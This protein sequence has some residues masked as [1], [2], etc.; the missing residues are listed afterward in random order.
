VLRIQDARQHFG[1]LAPPLTNAAFLDGMRPYR[2][3][4]LTK[5]WIYGTS[6]DIEWFNQ[7][8]IDIQNR[9]P[10]APIVLYGRDALLP[11]AAM[12]RENPGPWY[13]QWAGLAPFQ[14]R[15][16][17]NRF[18]L[19]RRPIVLLQMFP[20][21]KPELSKPMSELGYVAEFRG[22]AFL[23]DMYVLWPKGNQT[24]MRRNERQ[25]TGGLAREAS[26]FS[27]AKR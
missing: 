3:V 17:R 2:E 13:V 14:K 22:R 12:N 10:E 26:S 5:N 4:A 1:V 19:E 24:D 18:I 9:H 16:E 8:R 7:L 15:N 23:G 27:K 6:R 21:A 20:G 11:L 25:L